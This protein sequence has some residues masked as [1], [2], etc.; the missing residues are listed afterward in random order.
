[1]YLF[2]RFM[3]FAMRIVMIFLK[4][5]KPVTL[6]GPDS[7]L[8]LCRD[9][10]GAGAK[11][12]MVIT[13][14]ALMKLG[15]VNPLVEEL[16]KSGAEVDVFSEVQPDPSIEVVN[17][18][19]ERLRAFKAD[20]A[21]A[22]G[23][24]SSMDCAKAML[25]S[26]ANNTDCSKMAG[27]WMYHWPRKQ[28]LPFYCVPTTAGTGSE[29]TI[30][31]V[32]SDKKAKTKY[33]II[34]PKMVPGKVALDP[35]LMT[36][37]PPFITAPTGMDALTHAVEAYISTM[38][39]AETDT[40]AKNATQNIVANLPTAYSSGNNVAVREK[41]AVA[42]FDA[43]LAFTRAGV[44]YVHAIAHQLGALYHV[45]HGLANAIVMPYV[46]DYSKPD[47]AHRLADL[48]RVA[49]IGNTGDSDEKLA[50]AFIAK[51][52]QMN[53][54]MA[55]PEKVKDLKREDFDHIIN[56]AFAEAHG[57]YGVPRYLSRDG[58]NTL[59]AQLLPA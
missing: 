30:A 16:K 49:G 15:L 45:P 39:T 14:G 28:G 17:Q 25:L 23:G 38:A 4:F 12:V 20:A 54:D 57:T 5:P 10:T 46:L 53:R 19:I 31:A 59:L 2:S 37:L 22:V 21:L 47:C 33:A 13:D 43:G 55:I 48:A 41:M 11:R 1:M 8:R 18:G 29:T 44:G 32:I 35:K 24:G 52:R 26:L 50:D 58:A 36:G 40:L 6:T 34:D 9:I 27:I 51:I 3:I 7:A 42:S 56:N